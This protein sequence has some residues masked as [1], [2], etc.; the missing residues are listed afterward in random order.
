MMSP[1]F[2][3]AAKD[4]KIMVRDR[5]ALLV[6]LAMPL[7]L[8][9]ILGSALGSLGE[10][11]S[12][13]ANVAI[14]NEDAG[15]TG[16]RFVDGLTSS[17]DISEIFNITVS[18]DAAQVRTDVERGDLQAA[19]IIPGDLTEKVL[20]GEPVALEVLQDPGSQMSAGIWAGVV[21][22][23]VA[24]AS[25]QIIAAHTLEEAFAGAA[26]QGTAAP[27]GAGSVPSA[28]Q[29]MPELSFDAVTVREVEVEI[30]KQVSMISYYAA[31]MSGMFLLFGGMF[32]AFN[33]V[34]ERREQTLARML[35]TP[36]GK[37]TIVGGKALG[38]LLIGV[39][40]F[41]VL[42]AGTSLLFQV[43]WGTNV[44]GVLLVGFAETI[45]A[46]GLAMTL[47][48]LG[49]SERAIGGIAPAFI[50]LFAALGGAMIP[51]EQLPKWLLPA[52]VL[53]PVY[54][55]VDSFLE[56]MRGASLAA[57]A[58]NIAAVLAIGVVLFWFG[59]W[60]LRYE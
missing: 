33:F 54:W 44:P 59:V 51:A 10:G 56:L 5:A 6:M 36:A 46:A 17:E 27:E 1:L 37:V 9:F 7:A 8:I 57:V 15:D 52:Q 2:T 53:S 45:A 3:I 18:D 30:E 40:Q 24:N 28:A 29:Q 43:D 58:P 14:V 60:R 35:S 20:A 38:V 21:R 42:F 16:E 47:A 34:R 39:L 13:N 19:L 48:A 49:R 31:A 26:G 55:T 23:G 4:T 11:G 25:A 22:A 41:I 32:G 12:L 50:M